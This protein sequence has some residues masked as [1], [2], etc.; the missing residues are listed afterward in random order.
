MGNNFSAKDYQAQIALFSGEFLTHE[1]SG[2]LNNFI[3]QSD[4]FYNVSTTCLLDD[5][6]KIKIEKIDNF[7]YLM[8]YVSMK[9]FYPR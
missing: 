9:I 6:R 3:L 2:T 1:D 7:V 5:F 8:S 4:D